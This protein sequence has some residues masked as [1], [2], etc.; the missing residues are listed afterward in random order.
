MNKPFQQTLSSKSWVDSCQFPSR[1]RHTFSYRMW[2]TEGNTLSEAESFSL[3][4]AGPPTA[5]QATW[6]DLVGLVSLSDF[7]ALRCCVKDRTIFLNGRCVGPTP[8][9]CAL[10]LS[11]SKS[12][13]LKGKVDLAMYL[14]CNAGQSPLWPANPRVPTLRVRMR[15]LLSDVS[16]LCHV[17]GALKDHTRLEDPDH[18]QLRAL[19]KKF[20]AGEPFIDLKQQGTARTPH[21]S[22][23]GEGC[24]PETLPV[25]DICTF[26]ACKIINT[27]GELHICCI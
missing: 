19:Q 24:R 4:N 14:P 17:R 20:I 18:G 9:N 1:S 11:H 15:S 26:G 22:M 7:D 3:P 21:Q 25:G 8:A 6:V 12:N 5:L 23:R 10:P 16:A 2:R 13:S 27:L